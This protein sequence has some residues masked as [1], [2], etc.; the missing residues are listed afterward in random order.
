MSLY[1]QILIKFS[2]EKS[3]KVCHKIY[4]F[5]PKCRIEEKKQN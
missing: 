3:D 2:N 1:F 4:N 5:G